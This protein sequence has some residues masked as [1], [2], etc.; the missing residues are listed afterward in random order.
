MKTQSEIDAIID[1]IRAGRVEQKRG[2]QQLLEE[3]NINSC[4]RWTIRR[5]AT[6]ATEQEIDD[7]VS[8]TWLAIYSSFSTFDPQKASFKTWAETIARNKTVDH[9]RAMD[10][11]LDERSLDAPTGSSDRTP[12]DDLITADRSPLQSV[13][14]KRIVADVLVAMMGE[15]S[16][17][18][19]TLY[20]LRLNYDLTYDELAQ[21]A[22]TALGRTFTEKAVQNRIYRAQQKVYEALTKRREKGQAGRE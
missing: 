16:D 19:R 12:A 1:D 9:I 17:V 11:G 15:L 2:F 21:I 22:S 8:T 4:I 10:R 6:V 3:T 14:H 20:L 18:N 5:T 13:I 7:L